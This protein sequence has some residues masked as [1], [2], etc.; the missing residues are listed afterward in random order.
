[1]TDTYEVNGRRQGG[2]GGG[3]EKYEIKRLWP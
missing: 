2:I 1:M 3:S